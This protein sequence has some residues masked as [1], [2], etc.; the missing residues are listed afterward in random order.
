MIKLRSAVSS[1]RAQGVTASLINLPT[2]LPA[3]EQRLGL[4]GFTWQQYDAL[5]GLFM[6]QFPALRMTYLESVLKLRS[7]SRKPS[8]KIL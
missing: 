8:R 2:Q 7:T 3:D 6:N 4:E 1:E 5:V